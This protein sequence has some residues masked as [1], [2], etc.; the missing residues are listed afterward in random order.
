MASFVGSFI[1]RRERKYFIILRK[2]KVRLKLSENK[3]ELIIEKKRSLKKSYRNKFL[4]IYRLCQNFS[5]F[6]YWSA[7]L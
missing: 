2:E 4:L 6:N 5:R 1:T 3:Q 7:D